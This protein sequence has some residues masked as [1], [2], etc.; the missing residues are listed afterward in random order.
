MQFKKHRDTTVRHRRTRMAGETDEA[1]VPSVLVPPAAH[2][3]IGAKPADHA[4]IRRIE[5]ER[6]VVE[7]ICPSGG[8][9]RES[10][11]S[12]VVASTAGDDGWT[13]R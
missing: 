7:H 3:E 4:R 10:S 2:A 1:D 11:L 9:A 13:H 12:S 6:P 5:D 8:R